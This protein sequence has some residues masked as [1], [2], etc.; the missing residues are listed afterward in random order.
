MAVSRRFLM[1]RSGIEPV[2]FGLQNRHARQQEP[3]FRDLVSVSVCFRDRELR[4]R[5]PRAEV[6]AL[7]R[8]QLLP[9]ELLCRGSNKQRHE[10]G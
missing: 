7:V 4:N 9:L 3:C 2:I 1:E 10:T 5:G 6:T 8:S